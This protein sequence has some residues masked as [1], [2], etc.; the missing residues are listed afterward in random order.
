MVEIKEV[1]LKDLSKVISTREPRGLF[2]GYDLA[3][4]S[5]HTSFIAVDNSTGDAWT[6]EFYMKEAAKKW[7]EGVYDDIIYDINE[8]GDYWAIYRNGVR[9][10][11]H[12]KRSN[13]IENIKSKYGLKTI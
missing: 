11:K 5:S 6:E 12:P 9:L 2:I 8:E 10:Y 1:N 13:D 7:L 4:G 3:K